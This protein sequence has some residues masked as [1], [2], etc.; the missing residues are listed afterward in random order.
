MLIGRAEEQQALG[1]LVAAARVGQSGVLVLSGEAGIGK[2]ALL[3]HAVDLADGMQVLRVAGTPPERDVAFA[4]LHRLLR[5]ALGHL[6][7]L[8]GPQAE[9][10][11][12]ALALR[13]GER[14]DRFAV[15]AGTLGLLSRYAEERPLL[16]VID[17]LHTLDRPSAEALTFA[18][19]RLMADRVA[20]LIGTRPDADSPATGLPVLELRGLPVDR[21]AELLHR[22]SGGV[23]SRDVVARLHTATGG[24]PLALVELAG[25]DIRLDRLAPHTPVPLPGSLGGLF[26]RR[27]DRLDEAARRVLLL[28]VVAD[29]DLAVVERAAAGLGLDPGLVTVAE[30]EGLVVAGAGRVSF[31][32]PLVASGVYT[33]ASAQDRRDSH[34][35]VALALPEG[36]R[37]RRAWH[38]SEAAVGIDEDVSAELVAVG[39]RAGNRGAHAV[40]ATAFERSGLLTGDL[41]RRAARLLSAGE[42]AWLAGQARRA[43][44]LL[45]QAEALAASPRLRGMAGGLRGAVAMQAGSLDAARGG[46]RAA[47]G[48][49]EGVDAEAAVQAYTDLVSACFHLADTH[50]ALDA[51]ERIEALLPR[52]TPGPVRAQGRM[53]AGAARIL[54]GGDGI[55]LIRSAVS[56]LTGFPGHDD[57]PL[58]PAWGVRG[59]LFLRESGSGRELVD[60]AVGMVRARCGIGQLPNLLWHLA[61]YDA[62]TNRWQSAMVGY[63]EAATLARETGLAADLALCLS[64]LAWLDARRGRGPECRE[65]AEEACRLAAEHHVHL[66]RAWAMFALGELELGLGDAEAA[67][68]HLTALEDL[69]GLLGF[70]DVDLSPGPERV[71]ALLRLG[72]ADEAGLV[73]AD[74]HARASAKSQPWAL[75]RAERALGALA[76]PREQPAHFERAL[77]LH[78]SSPDDY[79]TARTALAYGVALRRSR[80]RVAARPHLRSALAT[81]E[82]LGAMPWADLA[83][84]ELDATGETVARRG[85]SRL[86]AL[87]PQEL[88]IAQLLGA[89]RTTREA[90]TALFLSPK[91]VEYH[92]RHVYLKLDVHSRGELA[93]AIAEQG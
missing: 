81:F 22:V 11:A 75:A 87:T 28:A 44:E 54:A 83:A 6:D 18:A 66:A 45:A 10:L 90:A 17:D 20:V 64:G 69:L 63:Q 31:R 13:P 85:E 24:N 60:R 70:L 47:G 12:V 29:G 39:E 32:H 19:R 71:E 68:G 36:D 40:A 51:A 80:S 65:T 2:T 62:T 34:R 67:L 57:D 52:T 61:R 92:L 77:A 73:A 84:A 21:A 93:E 3:D 55:D 9:A 48:A 26:A 82:Q 16:V 74:Y 25:D 43:D 91:T 76:S 4:G 79:E 37:D 35:A 58:R 8:P 15:G 41:E 14:T 49:L 78:R 72:R 88:Q 23:V 1:R 86:A 50:T 53:A 46:L 30:K 89:G 27:L 5:P 7:A 56:E 42:S 33:A 59:V 38:R